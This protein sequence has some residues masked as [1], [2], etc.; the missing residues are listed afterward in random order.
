MSDELCSQ[1]F[2]KAC[3][4][5]RSFYEFPGNMS[6]QM[7][8]LAGMRPKITSESLIIL[9]WNVCGQGTHVEY[10]GQPTVISLFTG[11]MGLDLG[12]EMESFEI[13]E[14]LDNNPDVVKTIRKN[15]P[16]LPIIDQS[17]FDVKTKDI[18]E[19]A[20]LGVGEATVVIGGPPCQPF[21]TAGRRLSVGEKKGQLVFEF[22]R[23]V[24][25]A[26]PK[27]F[28][29]ENVSGLVS[30][31][32]KHISFYERMKKSEQELTSQERLGSAFE[33][34]LGEFEKTRYGINFGVVNAADYGAPQKRKR[35]IVFGSR[36]GK[37]VPLPVPTYGSPKSLEVMLGHRRPWVT[38]REALEGL[39]DPDREC[40]PFPSWGKYMKYIPPG[41]N[42]RNLPSDVQK[43]AMK[44]AYYSQGGRTGFFRRLSWDDPAPTLVTSPV[45]KGT[46]LAHPKEDRPLSVREYA[47]IQGFPDNWE[48]IDHI[49]TKY[50]LIG[51]AVPIPLSRA[52]ARQM[53]KELETET[54]FETTETET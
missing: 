22:I 23:V 45:F 12:F 21:S 41:G 34:L 44:G 29:F 8:A 4:G 53:L 27:F 5:L 35:L 51:E 6:T 15:R 7:G 11:A 54:L 18:L 9:S 2:K 37:K 39:N 20:K 24:K 43:E 31:A 13:R 42:W 19:Q 3:Y 46:V 1:L 26:Q 33:V 36:E 40:L 17:I 14:A 16:R 47:K 38:L 28:L 52:L 49:A 48:F 50:R 32:I 25:E 30:A 10:S